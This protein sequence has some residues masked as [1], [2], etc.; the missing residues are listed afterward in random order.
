M[1]KANFE[2]WMNSIDKKYL[3]EAAMPP[4]K[5]SNYRKAFLA[6]AACLLLAC[7]GLLFR[8]ALLSKDG[9]TKEKIRQNGETYTLLSLETDTPSDISGLEEV[10]AEPL[11][12]FAGGLEIKLCSSE[13]SAWVSWFDPKTNTQWCLTSEASTLSLLTTASEIVKEL[14]Y[15]ITVAPEQATDI[16]Y[17]AFRLNDLT[18]AE[19]SFLMDDVR[20]SYRMASTYELTFP[21]EV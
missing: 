21:F 2:L 7:T 5:R 15:N 9:I 4:V 12:W 6:A 8:H 11:A 14:G 17:D 3:E 19:T 20:Y 13:E 16:T 1:N 18:V 10:T